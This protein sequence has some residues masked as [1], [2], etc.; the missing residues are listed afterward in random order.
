VE[1]VFQAQNVC[2]IE[3]MAFAGGEAE[4]V[5]DQF[6]QVG[7]PIFRYLGSGILAYRKMFAIVETVIFEID[8]LSGE[9]RQS[10]LHRLL[11]TAVFVNIAPAGAYIFES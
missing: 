11:G 4:P 1:A 8:T 7:T 5:N 6:V 2:G 9:S 3:C 10:V